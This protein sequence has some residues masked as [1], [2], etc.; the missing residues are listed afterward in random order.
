VLGR[1]DAGLL[2]AGPG[3]AG[4]GELVAAARQLFGGAVAFE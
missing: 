4:G 2:G 3:F 1:G